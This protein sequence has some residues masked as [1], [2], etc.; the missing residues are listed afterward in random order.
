LERAEELLGSEF[1]PIDVRS[2]DIPFDY[3][4]YY[5]DEFGPGLARRWVGIAGLVVQDRLADLKL[6][7]NR[8]EQEL[9]LA[10]KRA[11]NL[12]PG[13]LTLHS[14]V[15]A[16]TK[17]HAHRIYLRDG[18]FAELTL[19][20][21]AGRFEPLDWTYPDYRSAACFEFL[22]RCRAALPRQPD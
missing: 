12:D 16:T 20:Y 3:T 9:T 13:L 6:A 2:A 22:A 15:L 11:A 4:H 10:G 8:L 19:R 7:S 5:D 14:L 18:I 17:A 1:G 21:H